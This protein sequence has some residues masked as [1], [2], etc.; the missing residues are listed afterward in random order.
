M[1]ARL[2]SRIGEPS[3]DCSSCCELDPADKIGGGEE[4]DLWIARGPE[5]ALGAGGP[6]TF[7]GL[8]AGFVVNVVSSNVRHL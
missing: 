8:P 2:E 5:L 7:F 3:C 6:G 4:F 1:A